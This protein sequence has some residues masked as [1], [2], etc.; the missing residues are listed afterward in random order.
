MQGDVSLRLE[1]DAQRGLTALRHRVGAH[2]LS[3]LFDKPL[4]LP[5]PGA[6]LR[7]PYHMEIDNVGTLVSGELRAANHEGIVS[8]QWQHRE[9]QWA[10]AYGFT[11]TLKPDSSGSGYSL[12]TAPDSTPV[13]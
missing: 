12:E 8:L 7:P 4:A 2:E 5:A 6:T 11:S 10:R 3:I 13:P 9:P 1:T